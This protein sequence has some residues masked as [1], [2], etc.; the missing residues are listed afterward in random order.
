MRAEGTEA[1]SKVAVKAEATEVV[2]VEAMETARWRRRGRALDSSL[3]QVSVQRGRA[4]TASPE[5]RT[6]RAR[7]PWATW[8]LHSP[9]TR[10]GRSST[11]PGVFKTEKSLVKTL[12]KGE[13]M[14]HETH[15]CH[16]AIFFI[17]SFVLDMRAVLAFATLAA[18]TGFAVS[19]PCSS[20]LER[21]PSRSM[22]SLVASAK[23]TIPP[24]LSLS[25]AELSE[26]IGGSGRAKAVWEALRNGDDPRLL[27]DSGKAVSD[28]LLSRD[29]TPSTV[30]LVSGSEDG[31][32]KLL[33]KLRDG[34]QVETVLIPV[35]KRS[36][37]DAGGTTRKP[38]TERTTLCVS[39]QVG[40]DR[41]CQFCAR[42]PPVSLYQ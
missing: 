22:I 5:R 8:R 9:P 23:S 2:T 34:L 19:P 27:P 40:C 18:A 12:M 29:V 42:L 35:R 15:E 24:F 7:R 33:V 38:T 31:T 16:H 39:S 1:A 41:G 13:L 28:F 3:L 20:P 10:P 25:V 17:V 26:Q 30:Q 6:L 21:P 36:P 37:S 32:T 14:S 4:R 11:R